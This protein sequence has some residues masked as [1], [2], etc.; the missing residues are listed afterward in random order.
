MQ[1]IVTPQG[2]LVLYILQGF[3]SFTSLDS[4]SNPSKQEKQVMKCIF[5]LMTFPKFQVWDQDP[6]VFL[7]SMSSFL[8]IDYHQTIF[9]FLHR[10][11]SSVIISQVIKNSIKQVNMNGMS[12]ISHYNNAWIDCAFRPKFIIWQTLLSLLRYFAGIDFK[13]VS[14][15]L[16]FLIQEFNQEECHMDIV[17]II[18]P[19]L[20]LLCMHIECYTSLDI[21]ISCI[22]EQNVCI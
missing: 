19:Q 2:F 3:I 8:E 16:Q 9:H 18:E 13:T 7:F 10:K 11:I 6:V 12:D 22:C 20:Y 17:R 15:P 1:N 4:Q 21:T 14:K 5:T